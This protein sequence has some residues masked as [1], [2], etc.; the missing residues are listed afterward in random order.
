MKRLSRLTPHHHLTSNPLFSFEVR[1]VR[2]GAT[3]AILL[4]TSLRWLAIF[5]AVP[6]L[7][8][9]VLLQGIPH[10]WDRAGMIVT[11]FLLVLSLLWALVTDFA[12]MTSGLGSINREITAGRWD[13]LRLTPLKDDQLIAARHGTV[14]VRVWRWMMVVIALRL[15]AVLIALV[16]L[17]V[18]LL[19][20][21]PASGQSWGDFFIVLLMFVVGG[22]LLLLEPFW[23][24]RTVTALGIAVSM[25]AHTSVSAVLLAGGAIFALWLLQGF[26][27]FSI[28]VIVALV[29]LP[30]ALL[31]YAALQTTILSPLAFLALISATVYGFYSILQSWSLRRARR[32]IGSLS[33]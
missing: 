6:L 19:R 17:M 14:Q 27:A 15:A 32:W 13:L 21:R 29:I 22:L 24:M 28:A 11:F 31:E 4:K 30:L 7:L 1:R 5:A 12:A 10:C 26:I 25:R 16:S 8:W 9:L 2:W 3:E 23:R 18:A 20:D 33:E